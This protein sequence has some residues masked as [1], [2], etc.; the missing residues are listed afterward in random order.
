M[1]PLLVGVGGFFGAI[2]RYMV[3]TWISS[4]VGIGFPLGTLIVNI[5]GSF[6]LGFLVAVFLENLTHNH[7]LSLLVAYGFIGAYTTYS[8]FMM[9][10]IELANNGGISL[11]V[12]NVVVSLAFGL[13]AV[14]LGL[15]LGKIII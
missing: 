14:F 1:K 3:D 4:V 7:N 12:V 9:N 2:S 5:S 6:L 11:A 10:S 8:A 13:T 15:K